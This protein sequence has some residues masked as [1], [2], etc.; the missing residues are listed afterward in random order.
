MLRNAN[1][2]P[3]NAESVHEAAEVLGNGGIVITPTRTNYNVICNPT[4]ESAI[5][6]V[7]EVKKRTKFGPL[8]LYIPNAGEAEK[9][10][11]IPED[12]DRAILDKAWPGE[13]TLIFEKNYP[14]P[15]AL[16][17]GATTIA[18]TVQGECT[19]HDIAQEFG[20]VAMTSANISGQGDIFVTLEKA[21][22][23]IG[24]LVDLVIDAQSDAP[25]AE[26]DV[27]NKSN[28]IIDLTF[29]KPYLV[30]LGVY[31]IEKCREMFPDLNE[32]S[33]EYK[34]LLAERVGRK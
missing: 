21:V 7:F 14:F 13:L 19:C 27:D 9:Y 15:D 33:A 25:A 1:V 17:M 31:P 2:K 26:L 6:K 4:D 32:D 12:F 18:L 11:V 20:P 34:Q 3:A 24:H 30:R 23:D 22:E 8:T 16:T 5:A 29:G 10:A 28:T